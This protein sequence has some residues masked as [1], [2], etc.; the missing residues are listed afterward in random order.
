MRSVG[1]GFGDAV[2]RGSRRSVQPLAIVLALALGLLAL[3]IGAPAAQAKLVRPYESQITGTCPTAGTCEPAEVIPFSLISAVTVDGSGD[4][5][6]ADRGVQA[7]DKFDPAGAFALQSSGEG[8]FSGSIEGLA[9]SA[10]A[11]EVFVADSAHDDLWGID[12]ADGSYTGVDLRP[13]G[14]GECCSIKVAADN[15]AGASDGDLYVAALQET[16]VVRVQTDGAAAPFSVSAS[17]ITGNE[18]TGTPTGPFSEP[19]AVAVDSAGHLFIADQGNRAVY[20]YEPS[21]EF[22]R[23]FTEPGGVPFTEGITAVAVDPASDNILIGEKDPA[24]GRESP[25][26]LLELGPTGALLGRLTSA[27]N[28]PISTISGLAFDSTGRLYVADPNSHLVFVFGP[29]TAVPIETD[30]GSVSNVSDTA[31]TLDATINPNGV[32][33]FYAFQYGLS[34]CSATPASCAEVPA[35]PT[36][37]GSG[38]TAL[39]VSQGLSGLQP[40][41]TYFYRLV[42]VNGETSGREFG[43]D[44]AFTTQSAFPFALPDGRQWQLVSPPDKAGSIGGI[45]ETGVIEAAG[46]GHA[47]SYLTNAPTEA[48]AEGAAGEIQVLSTR[49]TTGWTSRDL[50][51]PHEKPTGAA[52]R[53]GPEYRFF[54]EDLSSAVVQPFG[55]FDPRLSSEASEQ[56]AYQRTL[57]S[58]ATSCYRPLVT[59]KPGFANAPPGTHFGE[60]FL[61]EE[62]NPF[63]PLVKSVCGPRFRGASPD[64]G[65]LVISS[66]AELIPAAPGALNQQHEPVGSLYEWSAAQLELV[67]V[68]PENEAGEELPAPI[69]GAAQEPTLGA[70]VSSNR[71]AISADGSRVFWTYE[72]SLYLRDTELGRSIELD[73]AEPACLAS[74]ECQSG[75]GVFQIASVDGSRVFF[76]DSHRLTE[77]ASLSGSDLYECV[78][79]ETAG[80]PTC[81]LTDLTPETGGEASSVLGSVLGASADGSSVYFVAQGTLGTAPNSNGQSAI[82]GQPNLFLREG[83]ATRFIAALSGGDS[84][85]WIEEPTRQPTRVSPDGHRLTFVSE[86]SLTGYDNHD[87][88]SDQPDAEVFLYDAERGMITCASCDPTGARPVG[89]LFK[90]LRGVNEEGLTA[91]QELWEEGR[92]VAALTPATTAFNGGN[93][94]GGESAYQGRYLSNSGRLFFNSLGSLV[95]QDVNENWDVY[96]YEPA[97]VG[98]C[99]PSSPTYSPTSAGCTG[100]ISSGTSNKESAFLDASESGDDVFFLTSSKLAPQDVDSSRDVYDAHVCGAEGVP[101]LPEPAAPA[102]PCKG[103]NCQA[104][105]PAPG[106]A[107]PGTQSFSGEGNVVQCRKGQVK[108]AGKCVKKKQPKKHKKKHH[109]KHRQS[110]K[111]QNRHGKSK[112]GNGK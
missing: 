41:T 84:H 106:E 31:A 64:A 32:E 109:K 105:A 37:I 88:V 13:L 62:G 16:K 82:A 44:R 42:T 100:L 65:H 22:L 58:C 59:A 33:A 91:G 83:G 107:T 40:G 39:N 69:A 98:D 10:A 104:G 15:S 54:A 101:C 17:Y 81:A 66:A 99:S 4:L 3:A 67:S 45:G 34:A 24:A 95:P 1:A 68:L 72:N 102:E 20:E 9:Y 43:P 103:E 96:E 73:L 7:V 89:V 21:G 71:R 30:G 94:A 38:E 50:A 78:I 90:R 8:H 27:G 26:T 92:W 49:G 60:E 2:G 11:D 56:T 25:A 97:S 111:S 46:D 57:G 28:S 77:D 12:P 6:V 110:K 19:S 61:C 70:N 87:A 35:P 48:G 23:E 55:L 112:G 53:V 18:L 85:D 36:P 75:G 108:K 47:I 76:K 93:V 63:E 5:W 86:A 52:P 29:L 14:A 80:R 74:L 79:G 51:T